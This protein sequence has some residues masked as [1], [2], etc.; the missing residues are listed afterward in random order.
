MIS[1]PIQGL[2]INFTGGDNIHIYEHFDSMTDPARPAESVKRSWEKIEVGPCSRLYLFVT[3]FPE[4]SKI[5]TLFGTK[6]INLDYF[7]L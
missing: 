5:N 4:Y 3:T 6:N 7:G 1:G 2:K